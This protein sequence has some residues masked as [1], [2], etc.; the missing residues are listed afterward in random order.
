MPTTKR[1]TLTEQRDEADARNVAMIGAG[2]RA[3]PSRRAERLAERDALLAERAAVE[4]DEIEARASTREDRRV[5]R[6]ADADPTDVTLDLD[7]DE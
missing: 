6:A 2:D 3:R 7:D 4:R 5:E 1:K